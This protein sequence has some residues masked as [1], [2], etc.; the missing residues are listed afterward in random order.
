MYV[1]VACIK[2]HIFGWCSEPAMAQTFHRKSIGKKQKRNGQ[3]SCAKYEAIK[4]IISNEAWTPQGKRL[5]KV[6]YNFFPPT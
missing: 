2:L 3:V 4:L 5:V 6:Y 1:C